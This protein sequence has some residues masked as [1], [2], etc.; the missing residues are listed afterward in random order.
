MLTRYVLFLYFQNLDVFSLVAWLLFRGLITIWIR[1]HV[2]YKN[3]RKL[4]PASSYHWPL[5]I[6][7]FIFA[8]SHWWKE[9]KKR[10]KK[11]ANMME[12]ILHARGIITLSHALYFHILLWNADN[13]SL[14]FFND[15][16]K[17]AVHKLINFYRPSRKHVQKLWSREVWESLA[18]FK[19]GFIYSRSLFRLPRS[20]WRG[21][22]LA[23]R[24]W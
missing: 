7:V 19:Q 6:K 1:N 13:R 22:G 5:K 9:K 12:L 17:V 20:A 8:R 23:I 21:R 14:F 11:T 4:W 10:K 2:L 16:C 15:A 24:G 3:C 18:V